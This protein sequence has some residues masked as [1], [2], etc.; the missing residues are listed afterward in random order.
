LDNG[1]RVESTHL[2]YLKQIG[3]KLSVTILRNNKKLKVDIPLKARKTRINNKEYDKTPTY[4]VF[5][6]MVFQPLSGGYL[7]ANRAM[8]PSLL[9]Y[10]LEYTL[11]GYSK[12]IPDRIQS[13]RKQVIVL[14]HVLSDI[15]NDGYKNMEGSVIYS[16]N[17]TPVED[18]KHL[19]QLVKKAKGT[20]LEIVTDFGNK[21]IMNKEKA[22]NRHKKILQQYQIFDDR[23][24]DLK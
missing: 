15:I 5:A 2:E 11:Q 1:L 17:G 13:K 16:I 9:S 6:G 20:Y 8:Q 21:I 24:P 22:K 19:I 4:Y 12:Q 23:S 7:E 10:V 14:S 3:E 18:L